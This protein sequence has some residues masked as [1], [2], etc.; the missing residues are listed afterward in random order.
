MQAGLTTSGS[1]RIAITHP[2][3]QTASVGEVI[4]RATFDAE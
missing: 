2:A 3:L 1:W 4:E